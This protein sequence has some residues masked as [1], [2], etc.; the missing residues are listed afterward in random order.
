MSDIV[1]LPSGEAAFAIPCFF[2]VLCRIFVV[3]PFAAVPEEPFRHGFDLGI[4]R[5]CVAA[6]QVCFLQIVR[7]AV[8]LFL[9]VRS[10]PVAGRIRFLSFIIRD[11]QF[12]LFPFASTIAHRISLAGRRLYDM[13][14]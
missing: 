8:E 3:I 1:F 5:W 6:K 7:V 2:L 11:A 4:G 13:S 10:F 12:V 14:L 9:E